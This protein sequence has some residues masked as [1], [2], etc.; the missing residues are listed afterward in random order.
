MQTIN[1][2]SGLYRN[3][4]ISGTFIVVKEYRDYT[5]SDMKSWARE[6]YDGWARVQADGEKPFSL[7]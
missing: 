6:G 5:D 7:H 4:E 1:I 3:T 2:T